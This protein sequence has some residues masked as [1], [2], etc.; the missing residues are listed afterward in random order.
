MVA[1]IQVIISRTKGR[2]AKIKIYK[3][4]I[5]QVATCGAESWTMNTRTHSLLFALIHGYGK[6]I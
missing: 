4:L 5:G 1:R 3:T 2:C 6:L